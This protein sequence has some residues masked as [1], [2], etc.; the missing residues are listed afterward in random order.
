MSKQRIK[1]L[2]FILEMEQQKEQQD[3]K[4]WGQYQQQLAQEK[5]KV[6]ELQGYLGEY[7][8][9]LTS[10]AGNQSGGAHISGGQV[11]NII[12]FI[13]QLKSAIDQQ[14]MQL[15]LIQQQVDNARIVYLK[16]RAKVE[17]LQKL[18]GKRQDQIS[19]AEE[20]Q[21]QKLMDEAAGR[22]FRQNS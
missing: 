13:D 15:N 10:N 22:M 5:N 3:L 18:I 19:A 21:L 8:Q 17:A 14:N 12:S 9:G 4:V 1:R 11:Q 2:Q 6:T 7:Q 16:S 20:K